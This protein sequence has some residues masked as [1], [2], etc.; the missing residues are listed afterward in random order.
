MNGKAT[1]WRDLPEENRRSVIRSLHELCMLLALGDLRSRGEIV[2]F[3]AAIAA[4]EELAREH[5]EPPSR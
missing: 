2:A 1:A 4:L 5:D 3:E